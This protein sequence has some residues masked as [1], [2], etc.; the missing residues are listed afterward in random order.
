MK[1]ITI[2]L[3]VL[4]LAGSVG[5]FTKAQL[6][7]GVSNVYLKVGTPE[8]IK[9]NSNLNLNHY[10]V[11]V[12]DNLNDTLGAIRT[13]AFYVVDEGEVG[14]AAFLTKPLPRKAN[15]TKIS[16]LL[17]YIKPFYGRIEYLDRE[18]QWAIVQVI[19][20]TETTPVEKR[21]IVKPNGS[22]GFEHKEIP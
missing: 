7:A 3:F 12:F 22:G 8:L 4:L 21:Y 13:L 1:K 18:N 16:Q 10:N 5:A 14:E 20:N 6:L 9:T 11:Q 15:D 2:L 19:L 17:D